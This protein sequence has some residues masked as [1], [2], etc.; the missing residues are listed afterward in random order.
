MTPTITRKL[1]GDEVQIATPGHSSTSPDRRGTIVGVVGKPGCEH[2]LVRWPDGRQSVLHPGSVSVPHSS[3]PS[4]A[5]P[6]P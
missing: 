1:V 4:H 6:L 2:F 3:R 5:R